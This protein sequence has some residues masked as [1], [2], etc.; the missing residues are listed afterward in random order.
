MFEKLKQAAKMIRDISPVSPQVGIILGSGLGDVA[1][2]VEDKIIIPYQD[3][4][5]FHATAVV[6][7]A[8]KLI[9]GKISGKNIAILQGRIH[10]YEGH[11]LEDVVFP[12]RLLGA[13]G[14][15]N[16]IIT[17]AAGGINTSFVKGDLAL[18]EDHINLTGKNPLVGP[19]H[20]SMGPRFPD[21][22]YA[23]EPELRVMIKKIADEQNIKL[24][25]GVYAGV[26]GPT[27]ETPAEI[28]MMRTMGADMV[29]M[30]TVHEV[31][32]ARHL[33]IKVAGI[34][35]I[36][37]MAAGINP[38]KLKHDDIEQETRKTIDILCN[39]IKNILL[40]VS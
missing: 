32:A 36:S 19:N 6:G 24:Q 20:E 25:K 8:G 22:T 34:S 14:I 10:A 26:L 9:L 17:N 21:M 33:G 29:G 3:I 35:C 18:I 13:L 38:E 37:N 27:Y 28:K 12:V 23:Y 5:F 4:P 16:L 30:S 39:L 2:L 40:K 11:P 31:I 7:H 15:Q 1:K